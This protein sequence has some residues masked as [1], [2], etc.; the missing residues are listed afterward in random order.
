MPKVC[1]LIHT[2]SQLMVGFW[3][4]LGERNIE[5]GTTGS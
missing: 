3:L 4:I 1:K 5:L 2:T